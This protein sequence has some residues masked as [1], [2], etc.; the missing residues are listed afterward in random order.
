MAQTIIYHNPRCTKSRQSLQLLEEKG[1]D[2]R[3]I[4]YLTDIPTKEELSKII[5]MLGITPYDLL[6]REEAIFKE[7]FK[8][9]ELSDQGWVQAMIDY[10]KLIER[11]IVIKSGQARIGRP[12]EKI[13][14]IL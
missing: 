11:P 14:E 10:P 13:L 1:E 2:V 9:K 5:E 3:V 6:R 8:G 12:T 7:N 4:P